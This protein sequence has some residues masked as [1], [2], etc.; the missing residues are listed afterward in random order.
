MRIV[1]L[2]HWWIGWCR[3]LGCGLIVCGSSSQSRLFWLNRIFLLVWFVTW[4][5]ISVETQVARPLLSTSDFGIGLM[6]HKW[7]C[8]VYVAFSA[9]RWLRLVVQAIRNIGRVS[10]VFNTKRRFSV[11]RTWETRARRL[12]VDI[13]WCVTSFSNKQET[14]SLSF[15]DIL[16]FIFFILLVKNS[17]RCILPKKD[18]TYETTL[19][20]LMQDFETQKVRLIL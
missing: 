12:V 6:W 3:K 11:V 10:W 19:G 5:H 16:F 4:R 1:D 14:P 18:L 13:S 20:S 2:F 9:A 15:V 17:N 8:R 7:S